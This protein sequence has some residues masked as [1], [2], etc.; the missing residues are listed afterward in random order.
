MSEIIPTEIGQPGHEL[1]TPPWLRV[2]S[3]LMSTARLMRDAYD[4]ALAG[5]D[6]NLTTASLLAYV[7]EQGA[8][9]QTVLAERLGVGRAAA[10]SAV[11]RLE[12]RGLVERRSDRD[13]RRVWLIAPTDEGKELAA[14]VAD[15]DISIRRALRLGIDRHE[16]QMLASLLVRLQR[17]LLAIEHGSVANN[18][19]TT[20][21]RQTA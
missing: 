14:K 1:D 9:T 3:T 19:S 15:I 16:R 21:G 12:Q 6:L 7:V 17:N 13:D 10:G 11:D 2:E 8:T 18:R 5:I 20:N 4:S